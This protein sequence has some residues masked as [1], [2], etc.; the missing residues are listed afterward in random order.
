MIGGAAPTVAAPSLHTA[1]FAFSST[2]G[3]EGSG[4][5][6]DVVYLPDGRVGVIVGDACG[7]GAFAAPLRHRLQP[8]GRKLA[9][10][11]CNPAE[12]MWRLAHQADAVVCEFATVVYAVLSLGDSGAVVTL[13]SAGHPAP[14]LV[15][16]DGE[17]RFL[18]GGIAPPLGAPPSAHQSVARARLPPGSRLVLYTDGLIDGGLPEDCF[19][20]FARDVQSLS[21][22]PL[23][24]M[25]RWLVGLSS[26]R[27]RVPDDL[28]VVAVQAPGA[29]PSS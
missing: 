10:T 3:D 18:E 25:C 19:D 5:W 4:D 16:G 23:A 1:T 26:M 20:R 15:K 7:R 13:A 28:T 12:F 6:W 11:G 17:C 21:A 24:E 8:L 22:L 9:L 27:A 29:H 2:D 14:L